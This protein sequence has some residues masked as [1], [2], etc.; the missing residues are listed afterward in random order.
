[1]SE[2]GRGLASGPRNSAAQ[3]ARLARLHGQKCGR[4]PRP[5]RKTLECV[6]PSSASGLPPE[7]QRVPTPLALLPP[8]ST[9]RS[10]P[11]QLLPRSSRRH[12]WRWRNRCRALCPLLPSTRDG[13]Y[14]QAKILQQTLFSKYPQH[15]PDSQPQRGEAPTRSAEKESNNHGVGIPRGCWDLGWN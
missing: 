14:T 12:G 2:S 6:Y 5:F 11:P 9:L 3:F 7:S 1:M 13:W 10:G 8:C 15:T 4:D